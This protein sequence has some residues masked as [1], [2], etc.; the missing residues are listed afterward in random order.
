MHTARLRAGSWHI[1]GEI[2]E[3]K[4]HFDFTLIR[5]VFHHAGMCCLWGRVRLLRPTLFPR[6]SRLC[7]SQAYI[8]RVLYVACTLLCCSNCPVPS[9]YRRQKMARRK[10][11]RADLQ[12]ANKKEKPT[13]TIGLQ[14]LPFTTFAN[15]ECIF[16]W[17]VCILRTAG[18]GQIIPHG[19]LSY[20]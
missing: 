1:L 5:I 2:K 3:N 15:S 17:I 7:A 12:Y 14:S 9:I 6:S 11:R 4:L 19:G 18:V 16:C 8:W 10:H 20:A 13:L